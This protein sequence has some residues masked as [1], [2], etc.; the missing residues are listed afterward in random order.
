M[1]Q[2]LEIVMKYLV[3][4]MEL[5]NINWNKNSYNEFIKYL[6]SFTY[7]N[8]R[9][10]RATTITNSNLKVLG[11]Y[12]PEVKEICNKIK[13]TN[14]KEFL[15]LIE[16]KY[17]E[18]T[19]IYGNL[20]PYLKDF[21]EISKYL[22]IL[23]L[24]TDN[25]ATCDNIPFKQIVKKH[26]VDLYNKSNQ[27]VLSEL[28][29]IRRIGL[30]ILFEYIN[31]KDYNEQIF[32]TLNTFSLEDEYYVNM[33]IGWLLCEMFIKAK[34]VTYNYLKTESLNA[35]AITIFVQKCRDSFR[36]DQVD[37]DNLLKYKK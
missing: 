1:K 15:N 14:I 22:N 4:T 30:K 13:K 29:F 19:M 9:V 2:D 6:E 27:Y 11:M 33:V 34:D 25:W 37:K 12:N 31:R 20:L 8:D 32:A 21:D 7:S 28:P 36:V 35:K 3:K 10:A 23:S 24:N 26:E 16:F 17:F 5:N 18:E